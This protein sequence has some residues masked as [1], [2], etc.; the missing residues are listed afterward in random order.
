MNEKIPLPQN[1]SEDSESP[2][3]ERETS[4]EQRRQEVIESIRDD[5]GILFITLVPSDVVQKFGVSGD[6]EWFRD[7]LGIQGD[8][9]NL[10][11]LDAVNQ[12]LPDTVEETGIIIGGSPFSVYEK[13]NEPWMQRLQE[14][15]RIMHSRKKPILGVCYGHQLIASSFGGKV[16]KNPQGR[17]FG[18]LKV[19]LTDAGALDPL[20]EGLPKQFIASESHTDIV[21]KL[22]TMEKTLV[23][24][25]NDLDIHQSLA[26]GDTTRSVQFHPEITSAT[27]EKIALARREV[28]LEQGFVKDDADFRSFLERLKDTPEARRV[29]HNFV[30][31]FVLKK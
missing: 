10:K 19:D 5:Y 2:K 22:P 7:A 17:D 15:L 4:V 20:Y 25:R 13:E 8:S 21:S 9:K 31:K 16:E 3:L 11:T 1:K 29:L 24:A 6:H 18:S 23:L 27:M 28:L 30:V 14:F 26:I 12:E